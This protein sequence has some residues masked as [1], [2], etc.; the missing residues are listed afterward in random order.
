MS[1]QFQHGPEGVENSL[2]SCWFPVCVENPYKLPLILIKECY[3]KQDKWPFQQEQ[4]Q[5][6]TKQSFLLLCFLNLGCSKK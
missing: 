5:T 6:D 2:E 4:G 1:Q 3:G